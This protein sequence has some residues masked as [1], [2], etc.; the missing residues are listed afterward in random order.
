MQPVAPKKKPHG[1]SIESLVGKDLEKRE[2]E[3]ELERTVSRTSVS[4]RS[5]S[6]VTE[7]DSPEPSHRAGF[8]PVGPNTLKGLRLP[9]MG[10]PVPDGIPW[11]P[12]STLGLPNSPHIACLPPNGLQ[13]SHSATP[14][15]IHPMFFG[16]P[17]REQLGLSIPHIYPWLMSRHPGIFGQRFAGPDASILLQPFR[18]PKR[19]RTAFSPSQLLRLEH[20]F[21]KNHYVVGQ[22]RKDLASSLSLTE[23]Q[24][25]VWFQN[26]RTKYKRLKAEEAEGGTGSMAP[27]MRDEMEEE[28][29]EEIDD[30]EILDP[31]SPK[32]PKSSHHVDR[33]RAET[34]QL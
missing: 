3:R 19:I 14:G 31:S 5:P 26:R 24:V 29:E 17:Q 30:D 7:R 13:V 32:M 4:S 2:R 28:E 16:P 18:K 10:L 23:T 9:E 6:P 22:E 27:D 15:A 1:F 12:Y 21:E 33:W 20:A 34:N 8:K 11:N 25:K